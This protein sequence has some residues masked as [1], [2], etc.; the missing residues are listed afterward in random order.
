MACWFTCLFYAL[1][2]IVGAGI[3]LK[4]YLFLITKKHTIKTSLKG[5][6]VIITGGTAGIGKE[7]VREL[8]RHGATVHVL[9]RDMHKAERVIGEIKE[10]TGSEDIH[11]H[12]V[13]LSNFSTVRVFAKKFLDTGSPIHILIN[14]AGLANNVKK[15]TVDGNEEITQANHLSHFLLTNLLLKRITESGPG[16]RIINLSSMGHLFVSAKE[17]DVYDINFQ[18]QSN[19][20]NALKVYNWSK[21]LNVLFTRE[22]AQ[23]LYGKGVTVNVVHPGGVATDLVRTGTWRSPEL[24]IIWLVGRIFFK[25][26]LEGA[27]TTLYLATADEV[28]HVSGHYFENCK[29]STMNLLAADEKLASELWEES[30]KL[31]GLS[32]AK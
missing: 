10:S 22:L 11:I 6:V 2:L 15:T 13:D 8:A 28:E 29:L 16:S 17:F 23:R 9:A 18:K 5:K 32:K 3:L 30:E 7:T 21:L 14:N 24:F 19:K 4:V 26:L 20:W 12:Q 1:L 27:Q 31:T 25:T